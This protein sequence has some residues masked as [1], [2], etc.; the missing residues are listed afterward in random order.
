MELH[1]LIDGLPV[2]VIRGEAATLR[3]CDLTD[4]SRTAV[5]GSLFIAR[6]GHDQDGRQYVEA[7]IEC[8]AVAVLTD[9]RE[10][11]MPERSRAIVLFTQD[12]PGVTGRLAERFYGEP[13]TRLTLVGVTGT[14]GKTTVAHLVHQILNDLGERCGL[15]GTVEIDDGRETAAAVLTTPPAVELSRSLAT[16]IEAGCVACVMET[17][18]HALDQQRAGALAFDIGVFTNLTGDHLDYHGDL[19]TYARAKKRLFD[20]LGP[21][22]VSVV[23]TDD[24]RGEQMAGPNPSRCSLADPDADWFASLERE[25]LDGLTLSLRGP[26]Y[27]LRARVP[28]IGSFNAMNTLQAVAAADAVLQRL[29]HEPGARRAAIE[30]ALPRVQAPAGRLQNVSQPSDPAVFVDFAHTDDALAS[31]LAALKRLVP[32]GGKLRVVFGCGG[33]K[34]TTKRP[35]MGKVA[36]GLADVVIVTSD[37]PRTESPSHIIS[38]VIEGIDPM[39]RARTT[40]H[41]DREPAIREA[42]L[43]ADPRDVILI[44][45]KGHETVQ[46][47]PDGQGGVVHRSFDD[48]LIAK[49]I[50]REARLR[51]ADPGASPAGSGTAGAAR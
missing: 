8:G 23:N 37:N 32:A 13:S 11:E 4:D 28:L 35:R 33:L 10:L 47:L 50:L 46:E 27:E 41:V 29:G 31:S 44:A 24:A 34:D 12:V 18:S 26:E 16:M 42:I 3:V 1:T 17:S 43:N 20:R 9:D 40:T 38:Q 51:R 25:S 21:D 2:T 48:R 19:E 36:A 15:I 30:H 5:P 49:E 22:G 45:G 7:A 39:D 14:N 6:R